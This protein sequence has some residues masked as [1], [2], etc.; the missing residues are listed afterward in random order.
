MTT[1]GAK[2]DAWVAEA[3]ALGLEVE[4]EVNSTGYLDSV[5]AEIRRPQVEE[6]NML[7]VVR[8]HESVHLH[9]N[10]CGGGKW[11]NHA[12]RYAYGVGYR[13]IE[14]LRSVVYWIRGMAE[15]S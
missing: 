11:S 5:S 15:T 6:R 3:R 12:S 13:K 14:R 7:D 10:R 8:N 9:A 4:I 2:F 1:A